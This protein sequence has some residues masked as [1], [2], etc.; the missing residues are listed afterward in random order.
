MPASTFDPY[1][2]FA[3]VLKNNGTLGSRQWSCTDGVFNAN[4]VPGQSVT[5]SYSSDQDG[6]TPP[7]TANSVEIRCYLPGTTTQIGDTWVI[8]TPEQ[9][10]NRTF[11][12]DDNPLNQVAGSARAGMVEIHL[13][14]IRTDFP[15]YTYDSRGLGLTGTDE[16]NR[17]FERA[18][19]T[20]NSHTL[21]NVSP[22]GAEPATFA[23]PDPVYVQAVLDAPL[24]SADSHNSELHQSGVD[25][26]TKTVTSSSS[27]LTWSYNAA[28]DLIDNEFA[29]GTVDLRVFL[30][31]DSISGNNGSFDEYRFATSGHEAGWTRPNNRRLAFVGRF[32]VDPSVTLANQVFNEPTSGVFN[33]GE[34]VTGTFEVHNARAEKITPVTADRVRVKRV[35]N[36]AYEETAAVQRSNGVVSW[37]VLFGASGNNAPADTSGDAKQLEWNDTNASITLANP[38]TSQFGFLSSLLDVV[39]VIT[40]Y[41]GTNTVVYNRGETATTTGRLLN[42]RGTGFAGF[43]SE[44]FESVNV[45]TGAAEDVAIINSHNTETGEFNLSIPFGQSGNVAPATAQGAAKDLSWRDSSGNVA[46]DDSLGALSSLLNVAIHLQLNDSTLDTNL[47][48]AQRLTSDLGFYSVRLTNQRGQGKNGASVTDHLRD[49]KNLVAPAD[50]TA[51]TTTLNSSAGWLPF[52]AWSSALPGGG[53]DHWIDNGTFEGNSYSKTRSSTNSSDYTLLA[54]NPNII[55]ICGGGHN[56]VGEDALHWHAGA[57]LL[58]GATLFN[59]AS[60]STVPADD[61]ETLDPGGQPYPKAY[62]SIARFNLATGAAEYYDLDKTWKAAVANPGNIY[63]WQLLSIRRGNELTGAGSVGDETTYV[64]TI[65]GVDTANWGSSELYFIPFLYRNSTPYSVFGITGVLGKANGHGGYSVDPVALGLHGV[66]G[67]R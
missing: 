6:V 48:T 25:I 45:G 61:S 10:Q 5:L 33:R 40:A 14:V 50:R 56:T 2:G 22:G 13:R 47:S 32:N 42:R 46:N 38:V 39:D 34:T 9:P 35:A 54:I 11:H 20:L 59:G 55:V 7:A 26:A 18:L 12:L 41:A 31:S 8:G 60:N 53:W 24:Y 36:G 21:S 37:S 29:V 17:G 27:T 1:P 3:Q 63:K 19:V 62:V 44:V 4:M 51:S 28:G 15:A 65:P 66:I 43:A 67:T 16:W 52:V 58:V 30:D 23:Y 64:V 57:D 49:D